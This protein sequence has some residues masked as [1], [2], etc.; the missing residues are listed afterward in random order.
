MNIDSYIDHVLHGLKQLRELIN[1]VNDIVAN[2][3]ETH[4]KEVSKT[5]LIELPDDSSFTISDFLE[6]QLH[7]IKLTAADLQSKNREV[8]NAVE[9]LIAKVRFF[10]FE[11]PQEMVSEADIEKLR[12]HYN[13]FMYQALLYSAKKSLIALKKRIGPRGG[14]NILNS[15]KPFFHVEVQ[16]MPPKLSLSPSLDDIQSC[17][18]STAK[19][20]LESYRTISSWKYSDLSF[21]GK[22][23]KDVELVRNA[24]LFTGSIQ[25]IRSSVMNYLETFTKVSC[26]ITRSSFTS[27]IFTYLSQFSMMIFGKLIR[28][29][30]IRSFCLMSPIWN[31]MNKNF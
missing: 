2:R 3:I 1:S 25:G 12:E 26:C 4:L 10:D 30:N 13:H 23:T 17:V 19:S 8:E 5:I 27:K 14:T 24:L 21:F 18:N 16:L 28:T 9:D 31:T 22:I 20:M 29:Q 6:N 11:F 15:N 7:Y